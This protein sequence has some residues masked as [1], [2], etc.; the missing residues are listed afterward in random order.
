MPQTYEKWVVA[1][2]IARSGIEVETVDASDDMEALLKVTNA[3][4]WGEGLYDSFLQLERD[5]NKK[6]IFVTVIPLKELPHNV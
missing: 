4:D 1:F 5:L 6:G 3:H 2:E